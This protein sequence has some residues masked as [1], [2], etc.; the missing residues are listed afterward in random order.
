[1]K[2]LQRL[3]APIIAAFL[4][5]G[6]ANAAF[7]QW[8]RTASSNDKADASINWAES[9]APSSINDS[10]RAMMARLAEW[11][12][13]NS[14]A[15]TTGGTSTAYT[16]T[17]YEGLTATPADGATLVLTFNATNGAAPTLAADSGTAFPLQTASGTAVPT[18][19]IVSGSQ[20]R[21]RFSTANSAWM[22][23]GYYSISTIPVGT[24]TPYAGATAPSGWHLADGSCVSQTTYATLYAVVGSAYGTCTT[25]NFALPDL[26]G[27]AAFGVDNMGGTPVNRIT[28]AGSGITGTTLG[29]SGGSEKHTLTVA[30]MPAHSHS[31]TS[32]VSDP[33]HTHVS[34][35][36]AYGAAYAGSGTTGA[37]NSASGPSQPS[38]DLH[39]TRTGSSTTGITVSTSIGSQGGGAAHAI[40]PPTLVVSYIIKV[41]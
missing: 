38:V 36:P 6:M 22:L 32:T 19:A 8:S 28:S 20:Y 16:V 37:I 35:D 39:G 9:M 24:V 17:T 40:M 11:R 5:A 13:D 12:D 26:R 29:A 25:G 10:A 14:G 27:R 3:I 15:L 31:A 2:M 7:Y 4:A 23:Q 41:N 21:L 30:E 34:V 18:G 1:M 33:G